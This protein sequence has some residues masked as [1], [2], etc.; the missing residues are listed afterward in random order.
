MV[1]AKK[2]AKAKKPRLSPDE[3]KFKARQRAFYRQVRTIFQRTGFTR[4][5]EA[6]DK[7]FTFAGRPGDFDDI[8]VKENLIICTEY[9]LSEGS[10]LGDHIKGKTLLFNL[11]HKDTPGFI[12]F[13]LEKFP[14]IRAAISQNYHNKQIRL[15]IA[16]CSPTEARSEHI[17]LTPETHFMWRGTIQYFKAL[18]ETVKLSARHELF[19]FFKLPFEEIGEQGKLPDDKGEGKFEGSLLPE[20]HSNF[21]SGY[22]VVSFYV[23][24]ATLLDRAYVLRKDGWNDSDG[25]YQRMIDKKK[26]ESI[27]AH[28][29]LKERVFV[30]NVI[31]TL[32]DGTRLDNTDN[33]EVDPSTIDK[34]TPVIV[35]IPHGANTVGIIDGQHRIFSYYEDVKDDPKIQSYRGRQNLL[36]TGIVYPT[37]LPQADR[38]RFEAGLFLEINSTQN[39]AKS[40]LKQ[41]IAVITDPYSADSIG[42]RVVNRLGQKAPLEG[43]IERHFFDKG[44]L[45]TSSMVSYALARLIRIDGDE[46][47]IRRWPSP[48][49][50]SVQAQSNDEALMN[51]VDYC[52]TQLSVFLSAIKANLK[53]EQWAMASKE[54]PGLLS[55][56]S[57]NSFIILFRK[58]VHMSGTNTFEGYKPNLKKIG[59][60]DFKA[61][62]SSRYNSMAEAI[63][64][65]IYGK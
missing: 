35:K 41:A 10:N 62:H 55:V 53:S 14:A 21:P 60:F 34:T 22:K 18:A 29:K 3:R 49:K 54:G 16:Y 20:T 9:T 61:Y 39:S 52:A 44:V 42:K 2:K 23:T 57:V 56:T 7:E 64:S 19:Q 30:N 11:I 48:D 37:E 25:L 15:R 26:I 24:P 33:K 8:F 13:L 12:E 58:V 32:P 65:D 31:V 27:R 45:K 40:D 6:T 43:L 36:A 17:E 46:S 28:L 4:I 38:S 5:A 47:L 50:A 1:G 51:Y 59:T 63:L